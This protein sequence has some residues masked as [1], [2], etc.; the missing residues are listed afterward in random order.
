MISK[1][2]FLILIFSL[3]LSNLI[4]QVE[5]SQPLQLKPVFSQSVTLN[6]ETPFFTVQNLS[7]FPVNELIIFNRWGNEVYKV[8]PYKGNWDYTVKGKRKDDPGTLLESGTYYYVFTDKLS[9]DKYQGYFNF[10]R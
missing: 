6:S 9:Q 7:L 10:V 5:N 2:Y 3:M 1:K 4:G 8:S